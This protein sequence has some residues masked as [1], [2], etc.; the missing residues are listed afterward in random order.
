MAGQYA[1]PK[2]TPLSAGS[3]AVSPSSIAAHQI[4]DQSVAEFAKKNFPQYAS[5]V[6]PEKA[7]LTVREALK[8]AN[9]MEKQLFMSK[10][11]TVLPKG[12][13]PAD[14]EKAVNEAP[15]SAA[16]PPAAPAAPAPAAAAPAAAPAAPAAAAAA[17]AAAPAPAA[18]DAVAPPAASTPQP[19]VQA[20]RAPQLSKQRQRPAAL[21][22]KPEAVLT[23]IA[24]CANPSLPN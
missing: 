20:G 17:P 9:F 7:K 14:I 22:R 8:T 3:P 2:K 16:K 11:A 19:A 18:A 10:L 5:M 15:P 4:L 12:V 1:L 6:P 21:P 23:T 13:T 24:R